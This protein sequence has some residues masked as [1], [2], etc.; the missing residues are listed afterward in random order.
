M[1]ISNTLACKIDC[2]GSAPGDES[3]VFIQF[4][5]LMYYCLPLSSLFNRA[6]TVSQYFPCH[7][8][9]HIALAQRL[10]VSDFVN[11]NRCLA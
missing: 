8:E 2:I 9:I 10:R 3:Q 1:G 5:E 4:L 6:A 11:E 7:R